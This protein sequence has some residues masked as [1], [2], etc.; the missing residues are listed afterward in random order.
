MHPHPR[1]QRDKHL[2]VGWECAEQ[3]FKQELEA[4]N[5]IRLS[6]RLYQR[7]LKEKKHFCLNVP[8]GHAAARDCLVNHRNDPGF[9]GPCRC[10]GIR[11]GGLDPRSA[12]SA[13]QP[14]STTC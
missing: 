7:C 11:T 13:R 10:G 4:D 8:P 6:V 9:G 5:D 14:Q 2:K 12:F 1:P 3:L